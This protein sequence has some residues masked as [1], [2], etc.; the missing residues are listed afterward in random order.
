MFTSNV[1]NTGPLVIQF[2]NDNIIYNGSNLSRLTN[3]PNLTSI[4]I[5]PKATPQETPQKHVNVSP[6]GK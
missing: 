4:P 5:Y 3:K 1:F 2:T 6:P